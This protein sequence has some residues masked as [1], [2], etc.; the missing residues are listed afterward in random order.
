MA[1]VDAVWAQHHAQQ[2]Y[3]ANP[4]PS[5]PEISAREFMVVREGMTHRHIR[6]NSDELLASSLA[7]EPPEAVFR[8]VAKYTAPASPWMDQKG[9]L[10]SDLVFDFD[11]D[12]LEDAM[13]DEMA[14]GVNGELGVERSRRECLRLLDEIADAFGLSSS[15]ITFSGSRGYHAYY[16]K[17][18]VQHL[19]A[20]MRREVVDYLKRKSI[21]VD[22]PVS[23]DISRQMRLPGSIHPSTGLVCTPL[24]EV[25]KF[26]ERQARPYVG[27][28]VEYDGAVMRDGAAYEAFTKSQRER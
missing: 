24:K 28:M 16:D 1:I 7:R 15:L 21:S 11:F 27:K 4:P 17:H 6:Y 20:P 3:S 23:I 5:I 2:W 9:W 25:S 18:E 13:F 10:G 14:A 19:D 26:T 8:S 12:H 22:E